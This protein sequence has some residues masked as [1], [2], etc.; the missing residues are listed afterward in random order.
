MTRQ[1]LTDNVYLTYVPSDKF[2]TG[3]LSAQMAVPLARETAG[4][5]ALLVNVLSRGTS[6]CPDMDALGRELDMLYGAR[7]DPTVRRKG[8]NQIFGFVASCIDD[9]YLS[10]GEQLLEPLAGL[11]GE[12]LCFPALRDGRLNPEYVESEQAN[13]IDLIRSDVND[14]RSYAARRLREEM[15]AGEPFGVNRLGSAEDVEA[16]TPEDLD[17]HYRTIL[18]QARLELFYCGSAPEERVSAAYRQALRALPRAGMLEPAAT[19]RRA[20]PDEP[21][22]V[23]EELDVTQGKLCIGY[24]TDSPDEHATIVANA[25]FGGSSN[26]KL[27]LNVREKLSLCYYAGSSYDREKGALMVSSGIEF[28]NYGR[29]M[30]E[31][32]AQLEAI[33][34]GD[35]EDWEFTGAKSYLL[36]NFRSM[37]DFASSLESYLLFQAVSGS[38]ETLGQLMEAVEAVTPER[39]MEAAKAIRPDTIYFLKGKEAQA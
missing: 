17:R 37:E 21:R 1:L 16:I 29:A 28:E 4:R 15:F 22:L 9:K 32:A 39:V 14:K 18:P 13:L 31:I 25:M 11:M 23:T 6:R 8:E 10:G 26:S 19:S 33:Q 24:R 36:N 7:L 38:K 5:N 3:F 30:T 2:K 35:W 34:R 12:M 27:F 20:A